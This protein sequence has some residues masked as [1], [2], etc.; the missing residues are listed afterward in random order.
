MGSPLFS[1]KTTAKPLKQH[2]NDLFKVLG[3]AIVLLEPLPLSL[4]LH[5]AS[6]NVYDQ[7][8]YFTIAVRL[9]FD[10]LGIAENGEAGMCL[11]L[12]DV[13]RCG[14]PAPPNVTPPLPTP[15][16]SLQ[17]PTKLV[18]EQEACDLVRELFLTEFTERILY[19]GL[20]AETKL[21]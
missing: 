17:L 11:I 14:S 18:P 1:T 15:I 7:A 10:Y 3:D 5:H 8:N 21:A 20:V 13:D 6:F 4:E 16:P 2:Q 9:G 19:T 12:S